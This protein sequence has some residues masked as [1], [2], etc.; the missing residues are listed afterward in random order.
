[1]TLR[2]YSLST[3]E[4]F[5]ERKPKKLKRKSNEKK[6]SEKPVRTVLKAIFLLLTPTMKKVAAVRSRQQKIK[7]KNLQ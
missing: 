7:K 6:N 4:G 1:M 3:L 2:L 5:L